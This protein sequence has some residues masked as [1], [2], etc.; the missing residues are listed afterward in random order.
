MEC[1][2]IDSCPKREVGG[3][4]RYQ[5]IVTN[6]AVYFIIDFVRTPNYKAH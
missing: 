2:D 3:G 5:T 6:N 4:A 1:I